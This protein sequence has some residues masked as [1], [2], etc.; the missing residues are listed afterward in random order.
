M[1]VT[2][3]LISLPERPSIVVLMSDQQQLDTVS[4]YGLNE[5]CRMPH[6]YLRII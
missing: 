1:T 5:V 3:G 6:T 2:T 4:C